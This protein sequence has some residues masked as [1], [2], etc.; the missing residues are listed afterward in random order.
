MTSFTSWGRK[1]GTAWVTA[2]FVPA[3][4]A[5]MFLCFVLSLVV[6]SSGK[7]LWRR[8]F[9]VSFADVV[10]APSGRVK[11]VGTRFLANPAL[12]FLYT[13]HGELLT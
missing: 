2:G 7:N 8:A 6:V 4:C 5:L 12:L 9:A 10:V 3:T 1:F 11:V 13:F